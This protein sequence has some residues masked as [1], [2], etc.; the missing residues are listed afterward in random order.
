[1]R[2]KQRTLPIVLLLL[3]VTAGQSMAVFS[4]SCSVG[5]TP[6]VDVGMS[7]DVLSVQTGAD[8]GHAQHILAEAAPQ[9]AAGGCCYADGDC[10]MAQ[11]VAPAAAV[12]TPDKVVG[13]SPSRHLLQA[14][15]F[16]LQP[17]SSTLFRPPIFV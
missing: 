14:S 17:A 8:M 4:A 10:L 11:C 9:A 15:F 6:P 2:Q 13:I 16:V 7:A 3:L 1:M 12:N 5:S